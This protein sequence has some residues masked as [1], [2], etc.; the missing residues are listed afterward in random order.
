MSPDLSA[1]LF[2]LLLAYLRVQ[3]LILMLPALSERL[4]SVRLRIALAVMLAPMAY[5]L[6]PPQFSLPTGP[7]GLAVD[8]VQ[9]LMAGFL[10]ALPARLIAFSL[11]TASSALAAT[12]SLSQLIGTGTEAAP[13]PVGNLLYLAGLAVLMAMG[14]P[15][16]LIDLIAQSYLVFPPGGDVVLSE[17]TQN[18]VALTAR[19]FVIAMLLAAPF[20]LGGLLYQ[21]LTGIVNRVMPTL[22][23]VFIGAPAIILLALAGLA[24]LSPALLAEWA[25]AVFEEGM[26]R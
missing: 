11:H 1:F 10:A 23:V 22:P 2:P 20:I 16:M 9:E 12:A 21:L 19:S 8:A 24:F 15:M 5:A 26:W 14:L 3:A 25:R 17:I 7:A 18:V 6:S 4:L 13:H